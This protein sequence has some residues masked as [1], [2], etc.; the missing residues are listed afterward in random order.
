MYRLFTCVKLSEAGAASGGPPTPSAVMRRP[1][2][3]AGVPQQTVDRPDGARAI[4]PQSLLL[5]GRY[6]L[7]LISPTHHVQTSGCPE[8]Q[9]PAP[10]WR[11]STVTRVVHA[12]ARSPEFISRRPWS[13]KCLSFPPQY[14]AGLEDKPEATSNIWSG[15]P[16]LGRNQAFR[17]SPHSSL[18]YQLPQRSTSASIR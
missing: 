4:S 14:P 8:H 1:V 10:R 15:P 16:P 2:G 3:S 5:S 13:V 17:L 7:D 18:S 12:P 11:F 6:L 9:S